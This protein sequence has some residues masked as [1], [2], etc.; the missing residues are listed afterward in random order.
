MGKLTLT[1]L[2]LGKSVVLTGSDNDTYLASLFKESSLPEQ[3]IVSLILNSCD[4]QSTMLDVGANIGYISV[5]M[6]I[7]AH[8]GKVF[9]FEPA[10]NTF[11]FFKQNIKDNNLSNVK[12]F[13]FGLSDKAYETTITYADDNSSGAFVGKIDTKNMQDHTVEKIELKVLDKEY[14]KLGITKCDFLKVDIEGHEAS[15]LKGAEKFIAEFKPMTIMEANHWCLNIFN[16][17]SLP[18]FLDQAFKNFPYIYA[19]S[20][21]KYLDLKDSSERFK[22]FYRNTVNN[23]FTNLFC[24]FNKN[25]MLKILNASLDKPSVSQQNLDDIAGKYA[26]LKVLYNQ[27]ENSKAQKVAKKVNKALGRG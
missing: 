17:T 25:Q 23:N 11:A 22:F 24:G 12:A 5:V 7:A 15:F 14:K 20:G 8:K 26:E 18:D 6:S 4:E 2:V 1:R 3:D 19:F 27:L 9:A 13:K 10:P 16:R 21:G